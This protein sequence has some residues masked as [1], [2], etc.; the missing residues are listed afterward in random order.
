MSE[1][2]Y[3]ESSPVSFEIQIEVFATKLYVE[4]KLGGKPTRFVFDTGPPSM[5][6]TALVD[7]LGLKT[8]DTNK[9]I[10][11]HGTVVETEIVQVNIPIGGASIQKYR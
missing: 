10:D 9:G 2:P 5:I 8:I 6:D 11:A 3:L 1:G 4:I 7:E